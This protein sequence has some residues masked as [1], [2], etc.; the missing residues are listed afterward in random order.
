MTQD[1]V[2]LDNPAYHS[3]DETH[4]DFRV[5]YEGAWFYHPDFCRFGGII[6]G[7]NTI[8]SMHAY[9]ELVSNFYIV[10]AISLFNNTLKLNKVLVCDQMVLHTL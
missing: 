2:K 5:K 7:A 8:E 10:G 6:P 4:A 1:E 3:L 9:T